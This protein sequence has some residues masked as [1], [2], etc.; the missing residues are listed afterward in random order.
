MPASPDL[1]KPI[2]GQLQPPCYA[3]GPKE[4]LV[5]A[6]HYQRAL[7]SMQGVL[8]LRDGGQVEIVGRLVE[9]QQ[10]SR[11]LGTDRSLFLKARLTRR[12][13]TDV[14]IVNHGPQQ[15]AVHGSSVIDQVAA[16]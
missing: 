2:P 16:R 6:D 11:R 9:Q 14:C 5:V 7:V 12:D 10:L 13:Q 8:Q 3:D 1:A 4:S 15:M